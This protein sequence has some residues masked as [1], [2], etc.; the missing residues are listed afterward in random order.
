MLNE[1]EEITRKEMKGRC[2]KRPHVMLAHISSVGR[3]QQ[4]PFLPTRNTR[5]EEVSP[6]AAPAAHLSL[7]PAHLSK[8]ETWFLS[9]SW[10]KTCT[11]H[12]STA[13]ECNYGGSE[14]HA[15]N[16]SAGSGTWGHYGKSYGV[17]HISF[18]SL[19]C[20]RR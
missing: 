20:V 18:H 17:R 6:R 10:P 3:K 11:T 2:K 8:E 9:G 7:F 15:S 4:H 16:S 12:R 5:A 13:N 14:R 1:D 19:T